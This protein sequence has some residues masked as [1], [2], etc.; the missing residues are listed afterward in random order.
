MARMAGRS[1]HQ[2]R[3]R[4]RRRHP[5]PLHRTLRL[6]LAVMALALLLA[7]LLTWLIWRGLLWLQ[8]HPLAG[9]ALWA[10]A[11]ALGLLVACGLF[12]WTYCL[13]PPGLRWHHPRRADLARYYD[14]RG[15]LQALQAMDPLAFERYVGQLFEREGYRVEYT[16]RSGDGGVDLLLRRRKRGWRSRGG[17]VALAQCKR[18]AANHPV[19][20]PELQQFSG[21]LRRALAYEGYVVTTGFFTPAA[22]EWA[23]QEGIHLIDGLALLQWQ[24]RLERRA[25]LRLR[26]FDR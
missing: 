17:E 10:S 16:P 26:A 24:C 19:G 11:L 20:S 1:F 9:T 25:W 8:S 7:L 15:T 5:T 12:Y 23:R 14:R 21:A 13:P 4:R 18:Y 2:N 6:A 22:Q 3:R